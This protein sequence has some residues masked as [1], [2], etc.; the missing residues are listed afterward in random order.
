MAHRHAFLHSDAWTK[1]QKANYLIFRSNTEWESKNSYTGFY[2]SDSDEELDVFEQPLELKHLASEVVKERL[3]KTNYIKYL[4]S[5]SCFGTHPYSVSWSFLMKSYRI[6]GMDGY[7]ILR[8][9]VEQTED[10]NPEL[11]NQTGS[12]RTAVPESFIRRIAK[13]LRLDIL[14]SCLNEAF[15]RILSRL[16]R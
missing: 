8:E 15:S 3:F 16:G 1:Q 5:V 6:L 10:L 14:F 2:D 13:L 9:V 4:K 11:L 12:I 7:Q